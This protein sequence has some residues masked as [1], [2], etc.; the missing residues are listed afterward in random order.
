MS[1]GASRRTRELIPGAGVSVEPAQE[2][3]VSALSGEGA[4]VFG[5]PGAPRRPREAQEVRAPPEA[6]DGRAQMLAVPGEAALEAPTQLGRRRVRR[7]PARGGRAGR[8]G[9]SERPRDRTEEE[10]LFFGHELSQDAENVRVGHGGARGLAAAGRGAGRAGRAGGRRRCSLLAH[11]VVTDKR[12][13]KLGEEGELCKQD[14]TSK[15]RVYRK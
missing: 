4:D 5:D 9:L 1:P 3:Q 2:L 7:D 6:G 10:E 8:P 13:G 15:L 11:D 14:D 12:R